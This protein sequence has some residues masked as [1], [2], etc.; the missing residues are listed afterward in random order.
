ML[1]WREAEVEENVAAS[2]DDRE[3]CLILCFSFT[4]ISGVFLATSTSL[5][6]VSF[7]CEEVFTRLFADRED[8]S[9]QK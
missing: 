1:K 6:G 7:F 2:A 8:L 9:V 5:S 3:N 4:Q